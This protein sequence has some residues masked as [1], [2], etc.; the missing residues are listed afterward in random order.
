MPDPRDTPAMRQHRRFKERHPDCVLFFRIGDFYEMFGD[1]AL[2]MHKALG[3]TLTERQP[4]IPMAGVPHHQIET[5]LKR[6]LDAGFRVAV[7][8]QLEEA[9]SSGKVV[10]RGVTRVVTPGTLV[11]AALI[12][13]DALSRLAAADARDGLFAAAIADL[14]T[15]AFRLDDGS[16]D[17][18]ADALRREA[19][20]ELLVPESASGEV[21]EMFR[22]LAHAASAAISPR[23]SWHFR[24]AEA[25]EALRAQ[26]GV[27][28]VEGF[29]LQPDDPALGP[30]GALLRYLAQTQ[31]AED[32][33]PRTRPTLAH[34]RSPGRDDPAGFLALDSL[35]LRAL[36]VERTIR[37]GEVEGSLL[38]LFTSR[39]EGA[40][41]PMGRRLLRQWLCRP[42]GARAPIETRQALVASLVEDDQTRGRLRD[43]LGGAGDVPRLAAR[44][45]LG[46]AGP[47]DLV[48]LGRSLDALSAAADALD[49]AAPLADLRRRLASLWADVAPVAAEVRRVLV[50][51]PPMSL[52][53]GGAVRDGVDAGLDEARA[54]S[55]DASS[56]LADYQAR[57]S[58]EHDLPGIRV[59][60]ARP[61]GYHIEL[62]SAQARRAPAQFTRRQTLRNAERFI[63]PELVEFERRILSA[64]DRARQREQE[65]VARLCDSARERLEHLLAA[66]DALAD[67]DAA[68]AFASRARRSAWSRPGVVDEP[69]LRFEQGWHPVL[70]DSLGDRFVPNDLDVGPPGPGWRSSPGPTWRA[71]PPS[72]GRPP[73]SPS[74]PTP[75]P[76]SPRARRPSASPT[77]SSRAS[78]RTTP[79]SPGTPPSWSR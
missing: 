31:T 10:R 41:T 68:A 15:G 49:R 2:A 22:R 42:L 9:P 63:T 29:G 37:S 5:Y 52:R 53:E 58:R 77:G 23:P 3:L 18:L 72:S 1:D 8:E 45:S 66:G 44:L 73:S 74:S 24:P 4:G 28:G 60:Y 61:F 46:R 13:D 67:V 62:P 59:G 56:W 17:E 16:F 11:D 54:L 7:V 32:D 43:A 76:S 65:L 26:F 33:A 34:L 21:P 69:V 39:S 35:S 64:E 12:A 36:E 40:R 57:L 70:G 20:T 19:V 55:R 27:A 50:D 79:S 71:S 38:G 75:G 51:S 6:A 14:S 25:M 30:A 78:A 47:R 48:S